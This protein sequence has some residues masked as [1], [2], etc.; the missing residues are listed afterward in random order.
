[1]YL[2]MPPNVT[3]G[4]NDHR[5]TTQA[6]SQGLNH[7]RTMAANLPT[8][9]TPASNNL[10]AAAD[11]GSNS[12][13]L[14]VARAD[15]SSGRFVPVDRLKHPV[16]L[17]RDLPSSCVISTAS[18]LRALDA[19]SDFHRLLRSHDVPL[20]NTRLVA[21]AA[22]RQA[23]NQSPFLS[24]IRQTLGLE[25]EVISGEE[26]ARLTYL[27][28][29]QFCPL[30]NQRVLTVDIGGGSTE[31]VIGKEGEVEFGA[32]LKL[33]H[34]TL[35]EEFVKRNEITTMREEIRSVIRR[36]GLIEKVREHGFEVAVGSSGTIRAIEKAVSRGYCEGDVGLFDRCRRDWR[37]SRGELGK[38]AGKL[39]GEEVGRE[40]KVRRERFF[41]RRS[42]FIVAGAVLLEEIFGM[43]GIEEMEVSGYSLGEGVVA[44]LVDGV[45]GD[46]DLK[47]NARWRS[48][49]R[50]AD[51]FN[52]KTRMKSAASCA[53]IAKGMFEGLMK[54]NELGDS[55]NKL[56]CSLDDK[57]LE[58]L[59]AACLL[60]NIGLFT[61]KKGY[62]KQSYHIIMDS[63]QLRGY[64]YE[65]VKIIALLARHHRKKF[66][67][68][69]HHSLQ[70]FTKEVKQKFRNLCAI[71]RVSVLVQQY[72]SINS[73]VMEF[74]HS[75]HGFKLVLGQIRD[76]PLELGDG[77]VQH[78]AMDID[79]ELTK[80]LEHFRAVFRQKL[81]VVP[82]SSLK[83]SER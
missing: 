41:K 30:F 32:S 43:M 61:V 59:E 50:L 18:Q 76:Q 29:L 68:L 13:K 73:Q 31:F 10:F 9:A 60:H 53:G 12:F 35:T 63:D 27:G 44:E 3:Q 51:R 55:E 5:S 71:I 52:N 14:V 19:L 40:E 34:V 20:A 70:G 22:L 36:S 69:D 81:V 28:V 80:E 82:S 79:A 65:E 83:S 23:S 49:E 46:F 56:S 11:L 26:E 2:N 15:P 66:P 6:V 7:H 4:S 77:D 39:C 33:G 67:K 24:Q 25:I 16:V 38:L 72:L 45:F 21:T 75:C 62:H 58:Y 74:S 42:E 64:N 17:G 48:I 57:D 8:L 47:A 37:F 78:L 54:W 1:M